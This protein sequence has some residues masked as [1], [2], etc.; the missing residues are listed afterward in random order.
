MIQPCGPSSLAFF[1]VTKRKIGKFKR[2]KIS[3]PFKQ[4]INISDVLVYLT[5]MGSVGQVGSGQLIRK[6]QIKKCQGKAAILL[7]YN[8]LT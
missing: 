2:C 6:E 1:T 5:P 7:S 8:Q 3:N 4:D